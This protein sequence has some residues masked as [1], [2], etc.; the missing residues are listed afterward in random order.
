MTNVLPCD[1]HAAATGVELVNEGGPGALDL[2]AHCFSLFRLRIAAL[3]QSEAE[4]LRRQDLNCAAVLA[5]TAE[6]IQRGEIDHD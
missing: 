3:V 4:R 1:R 5:T 6:K 2:L